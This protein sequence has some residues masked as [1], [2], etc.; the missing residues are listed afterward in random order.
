MPV[1]GL[2]REKESTATG[3]IN[4]LGISDARH[5]IDAEEKEIFRLI[6]QVFD[7]MTWRFF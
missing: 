2:A 7:E 6:N 1:A 5:N 4:G 3:V